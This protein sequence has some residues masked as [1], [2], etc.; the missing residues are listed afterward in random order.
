M[1]HALVAHLFIFIF[2]FLSVTLVVMGLTVGLMTS[3]QTACPIS[4]SHRQDR[5]VKGEKGER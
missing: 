2:I 3:P 5:E 4:E 1:F